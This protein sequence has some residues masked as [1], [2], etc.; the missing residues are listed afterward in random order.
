MTPPMPAVVARGLPARLH[1]WAAAPALLSEAEGCF[2]AEGIIS[3]TSA[4]CFGDSLLA[5]GA[6]GPAT[7]T[8]V[9]VPPGEIVERL[10]AGDIDAAALYLPLAQEAV[11]RLGA[12]G[13]VVTEARYDAATMN[14]VG[15]TGPALR[16][17]DVSR[18]LRALR[19][20]G[21]LIQEQPTCARAQLARWL[22][23]DAAV[24]DAVWPDCEFR[25][26]LEQT[27]LATL[28]SASR[29]AA[30]EELVTDKATPDDLDRVRRG[31]LRALDRRAV[32]L[33]K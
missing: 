5:L 11:R 7:V 13:A 32:T 19:R 2:A 24:V 10:L 23:L 4:L 33:V 26:V 18:L 28:E 1:G 27:L 15:R 16:D 17:D 14:L 12:R 29:W 30:R 25:V 22:K 31:P 3:G 20:A 8:L 9:P 21:A 6:L